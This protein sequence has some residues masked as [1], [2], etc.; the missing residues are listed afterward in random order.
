MD[1][2]EGIK[3]EAYMKGYNDGYKQGR[4]IGFERGMKTGIN[5]IKGRMEEVI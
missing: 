2:V 4:V 5:G 1:E 3:E